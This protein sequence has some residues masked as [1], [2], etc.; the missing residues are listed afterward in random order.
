MNESDVTVTNSPIRI[1][2]KLTA[3][4]HHPKESKCGERWL[5]VSKKSWLV[6]AP[7]SAPE[8]GIVNGGVKERRDAGRLMSSTLKFCYRCLERFG[9]DHQHF[10]CEACGRRDVK[11]EHHAFWCN[12][13]R[14][15][16]ASAHLVHCE[17]CGHAQ[18]HDGVERRCPRCPCS[19][20]M[21]AHEIAEQQRAG[22]FVKDENRRERNSVYCESCQAWSLRPGLHSNCLS[23]D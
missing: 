6:S 21:C 9:P 1:S 22:L 16:D 23:R 5:L 20:E 4:F 17:R 8:A 18:D 3:C 15:C 2:L 13:C 19:V 14:A 7:G 11:P 10:D 12:V